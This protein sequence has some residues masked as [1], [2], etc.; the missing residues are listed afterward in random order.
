[1]GLT[2]INCKKHIAEFL[3]I[4][5]KDHVRLIDQRLEEERFME[6]KSPAGSKRKK[7]TEKQKI[8]GAMDHT[9]KSQQPQ[10]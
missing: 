4:S 1:M 5:S 7:R 3:L 6:T 10:T 8:E 9:P 2:S